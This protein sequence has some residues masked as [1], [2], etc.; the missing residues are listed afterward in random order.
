MLKLRSSVLWIVLAC[1]SVV[2]VA[3]QTPSTSSPSGEADS[4]P[5]HR[6]VEPESAHQS[7]RSF[8]GRILRWGSEF[9]LRNAAE[10][11]SYKLDDQSKAKHYAGKRVKV[12]AT[13]DSGSSTLH[14][15][16][17]TAPSPRR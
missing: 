14:V 10:H 16:D 1:S 2:S 8:E 17:I 3:Q 7:A 5:Q 6:S 4:V 9:V 11:I 13:M 15:I 12:T